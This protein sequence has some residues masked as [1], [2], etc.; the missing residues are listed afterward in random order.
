MKVIREIFEGLIVG[1]VTIFCMSVLFFTTIGILVTL[2]A[3]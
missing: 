3:W 2:G 1:L